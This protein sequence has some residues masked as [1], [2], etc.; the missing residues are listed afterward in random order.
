M[1][2]RR[3]QKTG[4]CIPH[5]CVYRSVLSLEQTR[6]ALSKLEKKLVEVALT[7]GVEDQTGFLVRLLETLC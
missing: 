1:R 6:L 7:R 3:G 4:V 2:D 5:A